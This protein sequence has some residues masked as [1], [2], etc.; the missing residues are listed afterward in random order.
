[1]RPSLQHIA[2]FA[3]TLDG[4]AINSEQL[5]FEHLGSKYRLLG[6]PSIAIEWSKFDN[7]NS[8][9]TPIA[10]ATG[11]DEAKTVSV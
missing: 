5:Q 4:F 2:R 8:T 10:G 3:L 7:T 6:A 11:D 1:M 9:N